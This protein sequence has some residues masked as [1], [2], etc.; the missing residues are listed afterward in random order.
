MLARI[1]R[2]AAFIAVLALTASCMG[3]IRG[4]RAEVV[5][6]HRAPPPPR[7]EVIIRSPGPGH[8]WVAGHWLWRRDDYAWEPG[9]WVAVRAGAREYVPGQWRHDRYG[10]YWIEGRWR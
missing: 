6:V 10:W 8:V 2:S 3:Y 5:Y 4:P 9:V 1:V 7:T